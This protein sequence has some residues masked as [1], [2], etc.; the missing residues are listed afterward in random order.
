MPDSHRVS[1]DLVEY[2]LIV[3][4]D[5]DSISSLAEPLEGIVRSKSIR[6][7]DVAVLVKAADGTLHVQDPDWV[8]RLAPLVGIEGE[9]GGMLSDRDLELIAQAQANGTCGLVLVTE[10]RW[11]EPLSIA[12]AQAGG[13]VVTGE[14]IPRV[15]VEA[16]LAE[17]SRDP[18]IE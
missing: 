3:A 16:A 5:M 17:R 7:L 6:V 13:A 15:R 11:A 9:V 8:V 4:P 2:L 18:E 14:R 1:T 12:A 10:S